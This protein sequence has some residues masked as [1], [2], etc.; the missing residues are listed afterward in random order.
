MKNVH[1]YCLH[2]PDD[3]RNSPLPP[4]LVRCICLSLLKST[5]EWAYYINIEYEG[6]R[7]WRGNLENEVAKPEA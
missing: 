5:T 6:D 1:V 2:I 3:F 4:S 7:S